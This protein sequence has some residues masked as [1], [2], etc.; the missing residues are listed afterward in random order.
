MLFDLRSR[1]RRRVI[2]GVYLF[3]ALLIGLGLVG[4]GIG[5]G[6]NFGG[7]FN[8]ASSGGGSATGQ[9][10]AAKALR[11]AEKRAAREPKSAAAW[12]AVGRAADTLAQAYYVANTG[13][14]K[15]GFAVLTE[16]QKAWNHYLALLP[17][18]PDVSLAGAVATAFGIPPAG[19]AKYATAESAQEIVAE[20][21]P[22]SYAVYAELAYYA[23]NAHEYSRG[24]LASNRAI[25][26]APK[27][28][29]KQLS[30]ELAAAR[31]QAGGSTGATGSTSTTGATATTSSSSST[32]TTGATATTSSTHSK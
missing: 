7:L 21:N 9:V 14:E 15:Q 2:K 3:L 31:A 26:L 5:T 18:K 11:K 19:I 22:T 6:G 29:R 4:F 16:L 32:G 27:A 8:A 25:A 30:A 28:Q 17:A 20:A 12:A 23:Y 13:Y 24:D 10:I 1:R